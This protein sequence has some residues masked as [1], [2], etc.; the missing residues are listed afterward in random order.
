MRTTPLALALASAV[1]A[2]AASAADPATE[3]RVQFCKTCHRPGYTVS[4]V[5]T[6][7]GQP[8]EY[9][10]N[11][12]KA[13]KEKR[14]GS[15]GH[16]RYW[17]Q[18]AEDEMRVVADYFSANAPVREEFK[19][20]AAKVAAG[21]AKADALKCASCHLPTYAGKDAVPRLAGLHPEYAAG[22]LRAFT[23]GTRKH[24]R[25]DASTGITQ[26]DSTALGQ[27]FA[28]AK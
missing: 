20:D 7:D 16:Q 15:E 12:L 11:T 22:Q 14:R 9:L 26:D 10:L 6:L 25:I 21:K 4:Y 27:Y 2:P 23:A 3:E 24:P 1:A 19:V 18:R 17:G 5:P 28:Q 13:F 8:R